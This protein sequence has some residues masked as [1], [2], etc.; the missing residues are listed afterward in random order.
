LGFIERL[1]SLA[2][3]TVETCTGSNAQS[4]IGDGSC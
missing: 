2:G 4:N 3:P 1:G